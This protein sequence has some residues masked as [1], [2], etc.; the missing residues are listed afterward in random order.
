MLKIKLF[1]ILVAAILPC[2]WI[3]A[4]SEYFIRPTFRTNVRAEPSLE[5]EVVEQTR[6]GQMLRV[7]GEADDWLQIES[8]GVEG[9][10]ANWVGHTVFGKDGPLEITSHIADMVCDRG[11]E[12]ESFGGWVITVM[13]C[14]IDS[15]LPDSMLPPH[16]RTIPIQGVERSVERVQG[17]LDTL[18][19]R[20]PEWYTYVTLAV[21][22]I[23]IYDQG[24]QYDLV[25]GMA[26]VRPPLP[27]VYLSR[28]A[29]SGAGGNIAGI[30]IHEVCHLNEH[31]A[32]LRLASYESEVL[33]HTLELQALEAMDADTTSVENIIKFFLFLGE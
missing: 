28:R 2:S 13:D 24:S 17:A 10:M 29:A 3:A 16:E 18:K 19:H 5:S 30:I 20:A 1:A 23:I 33:C 32:G 22:N 14:D 26:Y 9:W 31:R 21:D 4:Q 6:A 25:S 12:L 11:P 15:K 8:D 7:V 27:T